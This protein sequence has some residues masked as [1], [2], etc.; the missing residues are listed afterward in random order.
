MNQGPRYESPSPLRHILFPSL[1]PL[2]SYTVSVSGLWPRRTVPQCLE[3]DTQTV[4]KLQG[5]RTESVRFS[6][7][8]LPQLQPSSSQDE[9]ERASVIKGPERSCL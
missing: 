5:R 6:G 8:K 2:T 3:E 9:E 7:H 1:N 4:R